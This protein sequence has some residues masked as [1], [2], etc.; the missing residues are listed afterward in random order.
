MHD[1]KSV[2]RVAEEYGI[3]CSTLYDH[4]SGKVWRG[5]KSGPRRYVDSSEELELVGFLTG[6]SLIGYS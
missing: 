5:A 3:P 1:G 6:I 4:Y 2:R